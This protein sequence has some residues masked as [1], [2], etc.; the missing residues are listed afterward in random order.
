K[1][2]KLTDEQMGHAIAI[3]AITMG[4]LGI[5]TDS[6]AREYMGSNASFTGANAALAASRGFTVNED[7]LENPAGFFA[8]YGAG[9]KGI[10][11]VLTRDTKE[12][13][14]TKY[15]AIRL[16]PGAHPSH[17]SGEAAANAAR[18]GNVSAD[19]VAKILVSGPGNNRTVD[20]TVP[21]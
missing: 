18:Q 6:W 9:P 3:V 21:R 1:L 4:G 11:D 13:D 20:K 8:T 14:I 5:G 10:A 16:V 7:M 19:D 12:C 2:L 15:L 17:A